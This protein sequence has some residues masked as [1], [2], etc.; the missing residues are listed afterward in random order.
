ME[1]EDLDLGRERDTI[2]DYEPEMEGFKDYVF[3]LLETKG[4]NEK[5]SFSTSIYNA[6]QPSRVINHVPTPEAMEFLILAGDNGD[7]S[8]LEKFCK[9]SSKLMF[10]YWNILYPD[11]PRT[12]ML[13]IL[14]RTLTQDMDISRKDLAAA[15]DTS[16]SKLCYILNGKGTI[17][18]ATFSKLADFL[19]ISEFEFLEKLGEMDGREEVRLFTESVINA[20]MRKGYS[21]EYAA[22]ALSVAPND[23]IA[24]ENGELTVTKKQLKIIA[25]MYGLDFLHLGNTAVIAHLITRKDFEEPDVT[26]YE[27]RVKSGDKVKLGNLAPF[28]C[29]MSLTNY[30]TD[31]KKYIPSNII[32]NTILMCLLDSEKW[33]FVRDE[34]YYIG[35][36]DEQKKYLTAKE[37]KALPPYYAPLLDSSLSANSS[38]TDILTFYRKQM[39]MSAADLGKLDLKVSKASLFDVIK[40]DGYISSLPLVYNTHKVLGC[41]FSAGIDLYMKE[42]LKKKT[43]VEPL[44]IGTELSI[45]TINLLIDSVSEWTFLGNRIPNE[46]IKI[47]FSVLF[48]NKPKAEKFRTIANLGLPVPAFNS[49]KFFGSEK[50]DQ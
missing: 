20:R 49:N 48:S 10:K 32:V 47:M 11:K 31:G 41:P 27:Q 15:L 42:S 19:N 40:R 34:M 36:I 44:T 50:T 25:S 30:L 45:Y 9:K 35:L 26:A 13:G 21:V 37:M 1:T 38:Y 24:L 43:N 18:Y 22:C 46:D 28:L 33:Q 12:S 14:F 4:V 23:Y 17:S 8:K 29:N 16:T 39:G 7:F 3:Y 6:I 2:K 5:K